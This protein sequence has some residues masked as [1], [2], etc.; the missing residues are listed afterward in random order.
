MYEL[1]HFTLFLKR[2]NS[3]NHWLHYN[4]IEK[5]Y[6]LANKDRAYTVDTIQQL[7]QNFPIF[8]P[9]LYL[10]TSIIVKTLKKQ[11]PK[12]TTNPFSRFNS[13]SNKKSNKNRIK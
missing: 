1:R 10:F 4:P 11:N 3:C 9:P 7:L 5:S 12:N 8:A 6:T 13:A 2:I